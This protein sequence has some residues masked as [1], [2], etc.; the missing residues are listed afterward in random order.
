MPS[1][2]A[3]SARPWD[4]PA[5]VHRNTRPIFPRRACQSP[6]SCECGR[7]HLGSDS[8]DR[9]RR[10]DDARPLRRPGTSRGRAAPSAAGARLLR[11]PTPRSAAVRRP[12]PAPTRRSRSTRQRADADRELDVT[13][14]HR[15]RR[16]QVHDEIDPASAGRTHQGRNAAPSHRGRREDHDRAR[17]RQP[18]RQP[19][20]ADVDTRS[21]PPATP[22]RTTP[23]TPAPMY[24]G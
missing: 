5:V 20:L 4:S 14:A 15:R 24:R 9:Y 12:R 23:A 16:H 10:R 2:T 6:D 8:T 21:A 22:A 3:T 17:Q 13:G 1:T 11:M 7:A 19:P 18:I